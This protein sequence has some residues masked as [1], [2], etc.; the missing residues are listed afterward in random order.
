MTGS[1]EAQRQ[2]LG[3]G[4]RDESA[5]ARQSRLQSEKLLSGG[6]PIKDIGTQEARNRRENKK[7]VAAAMRPPR[8]PAAAR[9]ALRAS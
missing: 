3:A 1:A 4:L 6:F 8:Q 5:L 9:Y 2:E 7:R